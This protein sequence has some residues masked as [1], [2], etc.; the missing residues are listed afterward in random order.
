MTSPRTRRRSRKITVGEIL[1]AEEREALHSDAA[2]TVTDLA[3]LADEYATLRSDLWTAKCAVILS[4]ADAATG[5]R[6]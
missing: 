4:R 1:T 6:S 3:A 2:H 5:A